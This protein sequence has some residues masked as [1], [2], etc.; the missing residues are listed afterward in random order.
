MQPTTQ[1]DISDFEILKDKHSSNHSEQSHWRNPVARPVQSISLLQLF[2][3]ESLQTQSPIC[4][5]ANHFS[6]GCTNLYGRPMQYSRLEKRKGPR[7]LI[8][9]LRCAIDHCCRLPT[10]I[11]PNIK[12]SNQIK[13]P[14]FT[15]ASFCVIRFDSKCFVMVSSSSSLLESVWRKST[16]PSLNLDKSMTTPRTSMCLLKGDHFFP[17]LAKR[18]PNR[19][20]S[21]ETCCS[22]CWD[23]SSRQRIGKSWKNAPAQIPKPTVRMW[24]NAALIL[25]KPATLP[26]APRGRAFNPHKLRKRRPQVWE[27]LREWSL[28]QKNAKETACKQKINRTSS[29][30]NS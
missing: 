19:S 25:K 9:K 30:Q 26:E 10:A 16:T 11:L 27:P 17:S 20:R 22:V 8:I 2:P 14:R 24:N 1:Q 12:L 13:R 3:N 29:P 23:T 21:I 28:E 5:N 4:K 18:I 7:Q 6:S 15:S